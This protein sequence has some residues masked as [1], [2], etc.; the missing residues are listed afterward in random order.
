LLN[1]YKSRIF[2]NDKMKY[3]ISRATTNKNMSTRLL[4]FLFLI[5]LTSVNIQAQGWERVFGSGVYAFSGTVF[6]TS[7]D[8][9]LIHGA[10]VNSTTEALEIVLRMFN[11]TGD[12]I[13]ERRYPSTGT[14]SGLIRE[15]PDGTFLVKGYERLEIDGSEYQKAQLFKI[16]PFGNTLLLIQMFLLL[17]FTILKYKTTNTFFP[18]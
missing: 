2:D 15:F 14:T 5:F 16:D 8:H 13:W 7:N 17:I 4:S 3:E 18:E 1:P 6:E 10:D 11:G 12:Q 9:F